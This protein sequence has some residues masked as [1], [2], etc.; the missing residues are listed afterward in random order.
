VTRRIDLDQLRAEA[1]EEPFEVQVQG[2]SFTLPAILPVSLA[3]QVDVLAANDEL[4]ATEAVKVFRTLVR[5]LVGD[6]ADELVELISLQELQLI[7]TTAYGVNVGESSAS[8]ASSPNGGT[9]PRPTS[10]A[11]TTQ[12]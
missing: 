10:P 6:R 2:H 3:L 9:P 1:N 12:S 7:V 8:V 5:G 11:T 4:S